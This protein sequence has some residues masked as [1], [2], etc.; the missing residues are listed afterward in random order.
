[1]SRRLPV[2]LV[3]DT[4]G[5]M[6]GEPIQA[7]DNAMRT[8][9]SELQTNPHALETAYLSIITFDDEAK[10]RIPLTPI[11][12]VQL[13]DITAGG[14]TALG[15]ALE[16][17][18]EKI[19]ND[20]KKNS[21]NTKGDWKPLIFLMTDGEPTDDVEKGIEQIKKCQTG[22]FVAC[23]AGQDSNVNILKRFTE[24]VVRLDSLAPQQITDFIKW[25]STSVQT[26]SRR[27]EKEGSG[28]DTLPEPP[29]LI[30]IV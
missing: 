15:G 27:P 7:L 20:V 8:L 5:S 26:V 16:L 22:T 3:L 23:A 25:I 30:S 21:G 19:Q 13:P 24:N 4:S 2:Y 28:L 6:Y 17:L 29:G 9:L 12:N 1:M 14:C 11:S 18:A 10:E